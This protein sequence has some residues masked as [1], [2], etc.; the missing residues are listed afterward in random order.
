MRSLLALAG[1]VLLLLTAVG[2]ASA[3]RPYRASDHISDIGCDGVITPEGV[4]Y[5][6]AVLSDE[7][8]PEASL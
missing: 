1:A 2:G 8:G 4:A 6:Y 7:D 3:G 5:F